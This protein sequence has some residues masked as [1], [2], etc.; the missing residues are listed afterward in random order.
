MC[1]P[2]GGAWPKSNGQSEIQDPA[3][4]AVEALENCC[5]A[6]EIQI[7]EQGF[8]V[9]GIASCNTGSPRPIQEEKAAGRASSAIR[10]PTTRNR[11]NRKRTSKN[12]GNDISVTR[13]PEKA[14]NNSLEIPGSNSYEVF[15]S[16][17]ELKCSSEPE[18]TQFPIVPLS[19]GNARQGVVATSIA[20][21]QEEGNW[22]LG[23]ETTA[24]KT[25]TED[26]T[27]KQTNQNNLTSETCTKAKCNLPS[28]DDT[29]R[30]G[31]LR[32]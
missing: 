16:P 1:S 21:K 9:A 10:R 7:G 8:A 27:A 26:L 12:T 32:G 23:L 15:I 2:A 25:K 4:P 19:G 6:T 14:I 11:K 29:E 3:E 20:E 30:K 31:K 17:K 24:S 13:T 28:E 22:E 5:K 18:R